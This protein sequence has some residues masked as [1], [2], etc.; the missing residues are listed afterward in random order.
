MNDVIVKVVFFPTII[1]SCLMFS[2]CF[3]VVQCGQDSKFFIQKTCYKKSA[4]GIPKNVKKLQYI[5][6]DSK[7]FQIYF[8]TS[9]LP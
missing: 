3:A 9:Y 1:D 4:L 8:E 7:I 2:F 5:S 6:K